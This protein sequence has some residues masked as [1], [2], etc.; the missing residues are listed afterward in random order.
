M[1]DHRSARSKV[2]FFNL[3]VDILGRRQL[4]EELSARLAANSDLVSINFLNAHCFNV[5]QRDPHYTDALDRCT[6]LLNDG[7]GVALAG[8]VKGIHFEE[9]MNGTDLIPD[10]LQ[11]FAEAGL[12]VYFFGGKPEVTQE[13]VVEIGRL[14]PNLSIAGFSHGYVESPES[15]VEQINASGAGAVVLGLGVPRQELWVDRYG[16]RLTDVRVCVSGGAIFD[17]MSGRVKRAPMFMRRLSLE[18]VFRLMQEPGRLFQ[19][20][21]PGNA[22]FL[23]YVLVRYRRWLP[24][25]APPDC[26]Q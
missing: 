9:N 3:R 10:L 11:L 23:Y 5:A 14:I 24:G 12:S 25:R 21:I 22:L 7:V 17:F 2:Q 18:W 20:Y 19:R 8:K 15:V 4:F 26:L 16:S 6:Y 1:D 13:A